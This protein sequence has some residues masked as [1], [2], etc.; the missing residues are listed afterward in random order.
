M[1]SVKSMCAKFVP[2]SHTNFN[3]NKINWKFETDLGKKRYTA[4]WLEMENK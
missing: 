1:N 4:S 3:W 2:I